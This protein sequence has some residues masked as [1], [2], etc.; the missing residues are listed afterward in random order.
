[1][2]SKQ[3]LFD[4][5][6]RAPLVLCGPGVPVAAIVDAPVET[7]ALF[8]SLARLAGIPSPPRVGAPLPGLP[9]G[10]AP[11]F[12]RSLYERRCDAGA[13]FESDRHAACRGGWR[14]G[15]KALCARSGA[16]FLRGRTL[17]SATRRYVEYATDAGAPAGAALYA[18]ARGGGSSEAAERVNR[19][20][21]GTAG[22]W[23]ARLEA[24]FPAGSPAEG[25]ES[26]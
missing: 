14:E 13:P 23:R 5:S 3:T 18:Y 16:A 7:L 8:A 25:A 2:W 11:R 4:A 15:V 22:R 6:L 17:R 21:N 1:M 9:G 12:A 26:E 20:R 24:S 19:A 10:R